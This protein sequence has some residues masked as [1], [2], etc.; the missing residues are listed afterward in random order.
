MASEQI[1]ADKNPMHKEKWIKYKVSVKELS[2]LKLYAWQIEKLSFKLP[3]EIPL[4]PM[5]RQMRAAQMIEPLTWMPKMATT[6][7]REIVAWKHNTV[8]SLI[9]YE[10][11]TSVSRAPATK[12]RP[13]VPAFRSIMYKSPLVTNGKKKRILKCTIKNLLFSSNFTHWYW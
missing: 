10:I 13:N 3:I 9:K 2:K 12:D 5:R 4:R 7:K 1:V 6:T 8:P 11:M